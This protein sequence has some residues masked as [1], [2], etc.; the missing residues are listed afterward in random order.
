MAGENFRRRPVLHVRENGFV[1]EQQERFKA[2]L[3]ERVVARKPAT[4][5]EPGTRVR[6]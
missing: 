2:G 5:L 6:T 4:R 1:I 3:V